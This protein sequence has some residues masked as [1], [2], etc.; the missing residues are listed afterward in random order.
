MSFTNK[1]KTALCRIYQK[2][3]LLPQLIFPR[4]ERAMLKGRGSSAKLPVYIKSKK[5]SNILIVT[6]SYIRNS[7]KLEPMQRRMEELGIKYSVFSGAGTN[8]TAAM[9]EKCAA[10]YAENS[11]D[12]MVAVGG[13]SVIDCAK[14]AGI[15][16]SAPKKDLGKTSGTKPFLFRTVPL[17][18][19]PTTLGA[20]SESD[21]CTITHNKKAKTGR[22]IKAPA[23]RPAAAV[24]DPIMTENIPENILAYTALSALCRAT[25]GYFGGTKQ[26]K[27]DAMLAV[28]LVFGNIVKAYENKDTDARI[29]LQKASYLSGGK[30]G[31][32]HAS[33]LVISAACKV[34]YGIAAA[35]MLPEFLTAY[36]VKA[37]KSLSYLAD[38][39]KLKGSNEKEKAE[40]FIEAVRELNRKL[41]IPSKLKELKKNAIP[42]YAAAVSRQCNPSF[43]APKQLFS[44]DI[45]EV[46]IRAKG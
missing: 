34:P 30:G 17:Y 32:A 38:S 2:T 11:C 42:G 27:A 35:V 33:A 9:A 13:G 8:P 45:A 24:L 6:D 10:V 16:A 21:S 40:A 5:H 18:A 36:G 22:K 1:T 4:N 43:E 39:V 20:G 41:G 23:L 7:G 29:E 3:A 46:L 28:R 26:Q 12:A 19:V 44:E 37:Y 31:Y 15:K 14:L 25:E